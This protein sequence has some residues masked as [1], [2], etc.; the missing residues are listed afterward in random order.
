MNP[1][2]TA[3]CSKCTAKF[4]LADAQKK[5]KLSSIFHYWNISKAEE[6]PQQKT[7]NFV[8]TTKNRNQEQYSN[9]ANPSQITQE[10]ASVLRTWP[11]VIGPE[12]SIEEEIAPEPRRSEGGH[13][14]K[15]GWF[16]GAPFSRRSNLQT[17]PRG[18]AQLLPF[19]QEMQKTNTELFIAAALSSKIHFLKNIYLKFLPRTPS[20]R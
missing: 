6:K 14:L 18:L 17:E 4:A 19:A 8:S 1:I 3:T 11:G 2:R 16:K 20:P 10:N 12:I 15:G 9:P 13:K 5:S 7:Y